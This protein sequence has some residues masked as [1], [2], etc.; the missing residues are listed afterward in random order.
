MILSRMGYYSY[1]N[2]LIYRHMGQEGGWDSHLAR[3][4]NYILRAVNELGPEIITVLGSGWLLDLPIAEIAGT[5]R[6]IYL[7]DIVHPPQV[8]SQIKPFPNITLVEADVSGGLI[9]EVWNKAPGFRLFKK[10]IQLADLNVPEFAPGFEPGI[11]ISL[12]VLT[13]LENLPV[14]FLKKRTRMAEADLTEFRRKVQEKHLSFL[15]RHRSI[16]ISDFEEVFVNSENMSESV[17][18][19]LV[20]PVGDDREEWTWDF[21]QKGSDFYNSRSIMKVVALTFNK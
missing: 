12:N 8:I 3:C 2:G 10:D 6:K 13:Q 16:L 21:D 19:M 20:N 5:A 11:V 9:M 4:R 7:V 14:E 18:T 1:Q 17:P 15:I